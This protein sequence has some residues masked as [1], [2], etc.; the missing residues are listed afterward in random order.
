MEQA[1]APGFDRSVVSASAPFQ[2]DDLAERHHPQRVVAPG[3]P[4]QAARY[5]DRGWRLP[6]DIDQA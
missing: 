1:L 3:F 6:D 2:T 5:A 4:E